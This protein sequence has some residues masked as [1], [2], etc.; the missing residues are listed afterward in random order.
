MEKIYIT[1]RIHFLENKNTSNLTD[2]DIHF[3]KETGIING[4]GGNIRQ[5]KFNNIFRNIFVWIANYFAQKIRPVFFEASCD[6]HDFGYWKGGDEARRKECDE[7]FLQKILED[8]DRRYY[9]WVWFYYE[10]KE[11]GKIQDIPSYEYF[12]K[13]F[14]YIAIAYLFYFAV[15]IGG[16]QYF[17]Y[18]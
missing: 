6:L 10:K 15:R 2:E 9:L 3:L 1:R 4:C 14:L 5:Q 18:K 7:K 11:C 17:N 13:K 16:K 8:I 12:F